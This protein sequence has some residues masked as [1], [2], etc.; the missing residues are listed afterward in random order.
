MR[1]AAR[2]FLV[3]MSA[4]IA[5]TVVLKVE[6]WLS[7]SAQEH[8][9]R[10]ISMSIDVQPDHLTAA[11]G[12]NWL[13]YH[14]DYSERC[15]RARRAHRPNHLALFAPNNRR[16]HRR[17]FAAPQSGSGHLALPRVS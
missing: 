14:G 5:L 6:S 7:A 13:S 15:V 2:I 3:L 16:S 8:V 12:E 4:T 11:A 17:R 1:S 10:A 9:D